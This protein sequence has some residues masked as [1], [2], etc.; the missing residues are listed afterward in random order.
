LVESELF[1]Y[2]NGAFTGARRHGQTGKFELANGGTLFLD[3]IHTMALPTQMKM[4]RVLEERKITRIGGKH[5]IELSFRIISATSSHLPDEIDRGR[6]LD[7][8]FYRLNIVK[9]RLP[10]LNER[11]DDI[12]YLLNYFIKQMNSKFDKQIL[13]V[14]PEVKQLF[15]RYSWPGNIRELKNCIESACIFCSTSRITIEDLEGTC[16]LESRQLLK[17]NGLNQTIEIATKHMINEALDRFGNAKAAAE[18]LGIP[19]S[20]FYRRLKTLSENNTFIDKRC[21]RSK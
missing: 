7:A 14:S 21:G 20:T 9:L 13:G 3:E 10:S 19:K 8:L 18:H 2:D 17:G 4:L 1:G 5:P 6:F 12:P 15:E 11:I 16:I